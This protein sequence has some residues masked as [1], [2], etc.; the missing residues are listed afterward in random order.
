MGT[1]PNLIGLLVQAACGAIADRTFVQVTLTRLE[2]PR[3]V[4]LA[5]QAD[6]TFRPLVPADFVRALDGDAAIF[7]EAVAYYRRDPKGFERNY[8]GVLVSVVNGRPYHMLPAGPTVMIADAW[9]ANGLGRLRAT[10][11]ALR[12]PPDDAIAAY[13][14]TVAVAGPEL[15]EPGKARP[16]EELPSLLLSSYGQAYRRM[17]NDLARQRLRRTLIALIV[18]RQ[19]AGTKTWPAS[20]P[21]TSTSDAAERTDPYTDKPFS[22]RVT[23]GGKGFLLYSVGD[24]GKDDGGE[25]GMK[26]GGS[27]ELRDDIAIRYP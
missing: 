4:A 17:V 15:G 11:A 6:A 20:L 12:T 1:D 8:L 26:P 10:R 13:R 27:G 3:T 24:N 19:A 25:A 5:R 2:D 22:Y 21:P 18:A 23:D 7:G 9:E 14:A 16:G